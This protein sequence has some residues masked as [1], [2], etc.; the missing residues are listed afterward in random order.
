MSPLTVIFALLFYAATAL[1]AAGLVAKVRQYWRTP[2]PLKI[3]TTPAPVT[4]TGVAWRMAREVALFESL[5]KANKWIW[6]FAVLF[7]AALLL[8]LLR[9]LRYFT[10]PVWTPVA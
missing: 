5:F 10:E 7:H 1:L 9:H 6:I 3:P 8:V 4:G 2:A